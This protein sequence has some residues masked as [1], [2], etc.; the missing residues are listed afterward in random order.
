M[1]PYDLPVASPGQLPEPAKGANPATAPTSA[2]P[3]TPPLTAG[4]QLPPR[5]TVT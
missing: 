3:Q 1:T 4:R 2:Q 5:Q